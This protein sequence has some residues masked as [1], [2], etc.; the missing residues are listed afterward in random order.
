MRVELVVARVGIFARGLCLCLCRS[1]S[2]CLPLLPLL[3]ELRA[4]AS[5]PSDGTTHLLGVTVALQLTRE[6]LTPLT[7]M[8][9]DDLDREEMNELSF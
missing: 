9:E 8:T 4:W 1:L 3:V 6:E 2:V 5:S 7:G